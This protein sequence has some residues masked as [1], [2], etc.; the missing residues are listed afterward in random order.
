MA[1]TQQ[2]MRKCGTCKKRTMQIRTV[3]NTIL[4]I[5]LT[6]ITCFIWIIIWI[7]FIRKGPWRCT[8]CGKKPLWSFGRGFM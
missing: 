7:L 5:F 1:S 2:D 8:V 3:P 6:L 4:H